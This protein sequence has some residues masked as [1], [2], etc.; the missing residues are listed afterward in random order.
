MQ[1]VSKNSGTSFSQSKNCSE[2][3]TETKI[4]KEQERARERMTLT[5]ATTEL[6]DDFYKLIMQLWCPPQACQIF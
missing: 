6:I 2:T 3:M 1:I 4:G 5:F